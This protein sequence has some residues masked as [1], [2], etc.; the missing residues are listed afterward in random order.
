MNTLLPPILGVIGLIIAF[1]IYLLVMK[2]PD[3]ED[4]V[5]R[6]GD[7]IHFGALAFMKTEYKYLF[8]FIIV[9]VGLVWMAEG[10]GPYTAISVIVGALCSSIAGFI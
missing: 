4:K 9:L 7:Q 5:K 8:V 3:G 1:V 6:I 10:L 2:Y